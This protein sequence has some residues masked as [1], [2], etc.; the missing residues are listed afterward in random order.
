MFTEFTLLYG[1]QT[2][3]TYTGK[4][5]S[6]NMVLNAGKSG[7]PHTPDKAISEA[8]VAVS[9]EFSGKMHK[10]RADSEIGR[11]QRCTC[12]G[13]DLARLGAQQIQTD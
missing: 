2:I 6:G 8:R 12:L 3:N 4:M 5:T 7:K 10:L 11:S 1:R 9:H 13:Q